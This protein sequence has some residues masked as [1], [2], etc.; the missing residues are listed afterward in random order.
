MKTLEELIDG[1]NQMCT[2]MTCSLCKYECFKNVDGCGVAYAFEQLVGTQPKHPATADKMKAVQLPAWCKV[3]QWVVA[4][5]D[6]EMNKRVKDCVLK[7][8]AE[9]DSFGG[10]TAKTLKGEREYGGW[11][12]YLP[13]RFR[14]Y[15]YDEAKGLLGKVMEYEEVL[16][17]KYKCCVMINS[18]SEDGVDVFINW[19]SHDSWTSYN[20]TIDGMPIGVPEVD[21]EALKGGEK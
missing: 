15:R 10:I 21:E 1:F 8:I 5:F 4:K 14:P 6:L 19:C 13:I 16:D 12:E 17:N 18:V 9:V 20:A 3:G 11:S 7:R 2:G